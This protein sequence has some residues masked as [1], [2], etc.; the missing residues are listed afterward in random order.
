MTL[1]KKSILDQLARLKAKDPGFKNFG[2]FVHQYEL[3][4]P[5]LESEV[6]GFETRHG[7]SLPHAYRYFV[8]QIGNGGA[9]P[10]YGLFPFD[11]HDDLR[12][13]I[14]WEDGYMVG[15]VSIEFPHRESWNLPQ[16]FWDEMPNPE[17]RIPFEEE[18][19]MNEEWNAKLEKHYWDPV[20]ING[21][22]PVSHL[23]C[24]RRQWLVING[25]QKGFVWSDERVDYQGLS[26]LLD[27]HE[28]QVTFSA[29]YLS[30]LYESLQS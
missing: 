21:A 20:V 2:A 12:G 7:I 17:P 3:Y 1:D 26:P 14:E 13:Y 5:V 22:I 25:S 28:Q 27:E 23:G 8:T 16:E 29:W 24:A 18:D 6:A 15:D 9:G 10:Y 19:R 11:Y 30:W 4:Q